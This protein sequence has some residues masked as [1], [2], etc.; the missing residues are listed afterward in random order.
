MHYIVNLILQAIAISVT[1]TQMSRAVT[2]LL[3][4]YC[5]SCDCFFFPFHRPP[6]LWHCT[7]HA[8][9]AWTL[10]PSALLPSHVVNHASKAAHAL[11]RCPPE[12]QCLRT[13][14]PPP[15]PQQAPILKMPRFGSLLSSPMT[16]V[17]PVPRPCPYM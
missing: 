6:A 14:T 5:Q 16:L 15:S 10:S 11:S 3:Y 7:L 4:M 13:Q 9:Q 2:R 1:C 8:Q 17:L 12:P